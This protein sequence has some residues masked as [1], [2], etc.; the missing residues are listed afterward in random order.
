[1]IRAL[2]PIF[3]QINTILSKYVSDDNIISKLKNLIV[4]VQV[5]INKLPEGCEFEDQCREANY[6]NVPEPID[7]RGELD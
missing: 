7:I 1:M 3:Y 6:E 4:I 2:E 5:E